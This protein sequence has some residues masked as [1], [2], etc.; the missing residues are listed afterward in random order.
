MNC[1]KINECFKIQI[2][3]D[4]DMLDFQYVEAIKSVCKD[5][6]QRD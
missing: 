2:I 4:K 3:M 5:C 1:P 6:K